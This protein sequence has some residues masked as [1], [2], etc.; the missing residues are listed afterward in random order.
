LIQFDSIWLNLTQF[1]WVWIKFTQFESVWL[2]SNHF[3]DWW[4][5]PVILLLGRLEY[6]MACGFN[7]LI[8]LFDWGL[9]SASWFSRWLLNE[10]E[11]DQH[12]ATSLPISGENRP[13]GHCW[14]YLAPEL[15]PHSQTLK[16]VSL[17]PRQG[18]AWKISHKADYILIVMF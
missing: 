7:G 12:T 10:R 13:H 3:G 17:N 18:E 15:K 2:N 9:T 11:P 8:F 16:V 6:G 5:N 4:R 1:R 14:T